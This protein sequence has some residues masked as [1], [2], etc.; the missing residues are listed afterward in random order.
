MS[1]KN[2]KRM[3]EV[4]VHGRGG[5][6]AVTAALLMGKVALLDG[7]NDMI[8]IPII[9]AERRGAPIRAFLRISKDEIRVY[10]GITR[11]DAVLVFDDSL[12]A[13]EEIRATLKD[14][15]VLVNTSKPPNG[16]HLPGCEIY[17]VDATGI[18]LEE[19]LL[20]AGDPVLNV[21]MMGAFA[22]MTGYITMESIVRV[23][24]KEFG[25]SKL[26]K[27]EMAARKAYE[28]LSKV[29]GRD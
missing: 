18:S 16:L 11:P 17:H 1:E 7:W 28:R 13:K 20:V 27:N 4:V 5:Q 21:P 3:V 6:G 9:G 2:E 8:S 10:S 24:S 23:V 29:N 12:L 15:A 26:E 14:C 25:R 22:R 19:E